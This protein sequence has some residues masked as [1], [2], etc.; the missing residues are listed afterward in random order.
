[1]RRRT[2]SPVPQAHALR[3]MFAQRQERRLIVCRSE[4]FPLDPK[5]AGKARA[6]RETQCHEGKARG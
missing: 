2:V 3:T 4:D 6:E 1:M 5:A